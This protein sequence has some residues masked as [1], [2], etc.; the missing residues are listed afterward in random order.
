MDFG[1]MSGG[2]DLGGG[3]GGAFGAYFGDLAGDQDRY[4]AEEYLKMLLKEY[5][6]LDPTVAAA[7]ED[8]VELGPTAFERLGAEMD[9]ESREAQV[10]AYRAMMQRGLSGGMD[11]QSRAALNEAMTEAAQQEAGARQAIQQ[12]FQ[13]RGRGGSMAELAAQLSNTQSSAEGNNRAATRAA[14]DASARAY[15]ALAQGAG[16]AGDVRGQDY[17]QASDRASARDLVAQHNARN[18][19]SVYGRNADREQSARAATVSNQF[20]KADRVAGGWDKR[21]ESS[22][23]S[24]QQKRERGYAAGKMVGQL[25]G[26]A[27]GA[28]F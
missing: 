8:V 16:L 13:T 23:L 10:R 19:Q 21:I 1:A 14:A 24:E 28:A 15:Q 3:L 6:N 27:I 9:P 12:N 26:T 17:Q 22:R 20:G 7:I 5:Q 4:D 25:L 2:G 18:R 11:A